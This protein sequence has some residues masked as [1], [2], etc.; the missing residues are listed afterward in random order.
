MITSGNCGPVGKSSTGL[1]RDALIP[2]SWLTKNGKTDST[3]L[4]KMK[5]KDFIEALQ[6]YLY[7]CYSHF[8]LNTLITEHSLKKKKQSALSQSSVWIHTCCS[9]REQ[10]LMYAIPLPWGTPTATQRNAAG[11]IFLGIVKINWPHRSS[12]KPKNKH[13][14]HW[15][16]SIPCT[17]NAVSKNCTMI[18]CRHKSHS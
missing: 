11:R 1:N 3:F 2:L 5:I 13:H 16:Q 6:C 17:W 9:M 4:F 15:S 12:E 7:H 14:I 8:R 18:I 10:L